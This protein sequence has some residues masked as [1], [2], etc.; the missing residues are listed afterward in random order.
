MVESD[1][2]TLALVL[3]R[4]VENAG[5][6]QREMDRIRGSSSPESRGGCVAIEML[7]GA[8]AIFQLVLAAM[9]EA[10]IDVDPEDAAGC[11]RDLV[12]RRLARVN[13]LPLV[14]TRGRDK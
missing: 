6:P 5:A 4:L 3:V 14:A 7:A 8:G 1:Y 10:G 2:D 11:T 12:R 9:H 13:R